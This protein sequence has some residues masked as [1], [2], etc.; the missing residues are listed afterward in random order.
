M[1]VT[2]YAHQR[3]GDLGAKYRKAITAD[4][5]ARY[6]ILT[7]SNLTYFPYSLLRGRSQFPTMKKSLPAKP[8][9][10]KLVAASINY[11]CSASARG[12]L[13]KIKSKVRPLF[14]KSICFQIINELFIDGVSTIGEEPFEGCS[15]SDKVERKGLPNG[16]I[17]AA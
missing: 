15:I 2:V 13:P 5:N 9:Q 11:S 12:K 10:P 7:S 14:C 1:V 8:P 3:G 17:H 4:N 6:S 16:A